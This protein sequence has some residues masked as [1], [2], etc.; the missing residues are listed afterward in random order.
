MKFK[1]LQVSTL[2]VIVHRRDRSGGDR[3]FSS[4]N[5]RAAASEDGWTGLV[6]PA[7]VNATPHLTE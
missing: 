3:K 1:H 6:D 5:K 4:C 7:Q 2:N